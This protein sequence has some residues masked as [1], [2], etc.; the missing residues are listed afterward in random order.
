MLQT[1]DC[2]TKVSDVKKSRWLNCFAVGDAGREKWEKLKYSVG[3]ANPNSGLF[4]SQII[5]GEAR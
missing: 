1:G 4:P 5:L 3:L 2:N